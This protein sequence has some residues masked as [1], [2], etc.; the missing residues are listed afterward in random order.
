M[1]ANQVGVS[2]VA[3]DK[4][5]IESSHGSV[6]VRGIFDELNI[7]EDIFSNALTADL[8]LSEAYNLP[9][10]LPIIGEEI[11]DI[12]IRLEGSTAAGKKVKLDPPMFFLYDIANRFHHVQADGSGS[13]KSQTYTL[14]FISEQGMS[15]VHSRVSKSY[16]KFTADEIV[17]DI[18][19]NYLYDGYSDLLVS[20]SEG[21][22]PCVIPNWTPHQAFNWLAGRA[23]SAEYDTAVNY[24]FY[25]TMNSVN[26]ACLGDL[27]DTGRDEPVLTFTQEPR[28]KDPT[29]IE[30][31]SGGKVRID[32]LTFINHFDR[33]KNAKRGEYASKLVTHDI[34]TKKIE[35]HDYNG[36]N[37]WA[38]YV[39]TSDFPAIPYSDVDVAM[40]MMKR[41][42]L[43]PSE[44]KVTEGE[45]LDTFTDSS[46]SF[47]PKHSQMFAQTPSHK[48]DNQA[49]L[50]KLQ[51]AGQMSLYDGYTMQIQ[52][53]GL[54]MLRVGHIVKVL[55]ASTEG[56][57]SGKEGIGQDKFLSGT[58]MVT[59]IRHIITRDG[60][61]MNVEVSRDGLGDM[62]EGRLKK[63]IYK[64]VDTSIG[65][66]A[67]L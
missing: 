35:Q 44:Y 22:L 34:V 46:V 48:Y 52:C 42:S 33:I 43:A 14:N 1:A 20:R 50:W 37:E 63:N 24:L 25:E 16:Q 67:D 64:D 5:N 26:F 40:A 53:A 29:N 36:L 32:N 12:D 47:Y 13:A 41:T 27:A 60:Y 3:I 49:E 45:R 30:G 39:H 58:Y 4:V 23:R 65:T 2:D 57:S 54:P 19:D 15:N 11:L 17:M 31:F 21:I 8:T 10:K 6:D 66:G 38:A 62:P 56:T 28:V 55:V 9:Y 51:R 18:F 7:Y 61:R 59:A